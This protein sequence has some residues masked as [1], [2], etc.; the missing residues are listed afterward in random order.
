MRGMFGKLGSFLTT[1][2]V[3]TVNIFTLIVLVY[4]VGV[5]FVILRQMPEPEDPTGKVL[6]LAPKG[7]IVDQEAYADDFGFPFTLPSQDQ[8]QTR[9]LVRLIRAAA[10]DERLAGFV[11]DFSG[12]GFSGPTT[13]LE[14]ADELRALKDS[15]KPVITFAESLGTGA[16]MMASQ[17][18]E[19][20]LHPSGGLTLTGLGSYRD[21]TRELTDKL[22]IT[23]HN[24]S[25]G[26][27]K[28]AVEGFTRTGMS[29]ADRE[30]REA[31][32]GPIWDA[33]KNTM[34]TGRELEP[35]VLQ[36]HADSFGLAMLGEG[37]YDGLQAA[38]TDG[39]IDGT[40]TFPEFRTYMKERFGEAED[41]ERDTYPHISGAAYFAQLEPEAQESEDKIAVVF[42]EGALQNSGIAPGVAGS[43]DITRLIREAHE[44]ES[45]KAIVLRVN[46]PGGSILAS[47]TIRDEL[48]EAQRKSIPVVVSMG[49]IAT[50]GGVWVSMS[51]DAIWAEP[52]TITGSIGV[53]VVFPTIE[54]V[55][56]YIGVNADGV[57]TSRYAGW[58]VNRPVDEQMDALFAKW[59][60]SAYERFIAGVALGRDKEPEY[61]RSIAGGRV[62][63]GSTAQELGLVDNMGDLEAAIADAAERAALTDFDVNYVV[64]QPS[65]AFLLLRQFTSSV[66]GSVEVPALDFAARMELLTREFERLSQPR[67][68]VICTFCMV[69]MH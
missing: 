22:K 39:L 47:D 6:I 3:W 27:Y 67:A 52:T 43:K 38:I 4:V 18:D 58:S 41:S 48:S 23:I 62:W 32:F 16:Y 11:I 21:Y 45:N 46:S 57:T 65:R 17:G 59:A 14:I 53:A 10:A 42:V 2:R 8:I 19:I 25:Q 55:M 61:V 40:K 60:G 33:M 64:K 31:L 34:A 24:Y 37:G 66:L 68:T 1:L 5:V 29:D 26:D 44:D 50:S 28:S 20:W 49:D 15:G 36:R 30:Q 56:D 51:A 63:I 12:A 9:D 7:Q 69:E 35:E 13:A 54:N